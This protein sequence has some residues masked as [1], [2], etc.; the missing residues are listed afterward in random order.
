MESLR[1]LLEL[2]KAVL[3]SLCKLAQYSERIVTI[4]LAVTALIAVIAL[5]I[6]SGAL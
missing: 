6:G 3:E 5:G 1:T 4:I 2:L